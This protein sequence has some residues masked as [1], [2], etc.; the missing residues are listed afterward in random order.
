MYAD[1]FTA[2]VIMF[3]RY[4]MSHVKQHEL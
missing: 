3:Y 4:G 1:A 2:V